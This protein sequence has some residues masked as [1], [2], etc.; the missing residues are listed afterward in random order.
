M[1]TAELMRREMQSLPMKKRRRASEEDEKLT[2]KVHVVEKC[3][4]HGG[5]E[6]EEE[7]DLS[8]P[9]VLH[10]PPATQFGTSK[11]T[12]EGVASDGDVMG[13]QKTGV[14]RS[15]KQLEC[16]MTMASPITA[17]KAKARAKMISQT[18]TMQSGRARPAAAPSGPD[19]DKH[20]DRQTK[21]CSLR[22]LLHRWLSELVTVQDCPSEVSEVFVSLALRIF[23]R[24]LMVKHGASSLAGI[25]GANVQRCELATCLWISM[26]L[27][28]EQSIVPTSREVSDAVGIC[29][30][31]CLRKKEEEIGNALKW[32]FM[33]DH[34]AALSA[35]GGGDQTVDS[36]DSMMVA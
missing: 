23:T 15:R 17:A 35:K 24:F 10:F 22:S 28:E 5:K 19:A 34:L 7:E 27:E 11:G 25:F 32:R 26:K 8:P 12:T 29:D 13:Q 2:V 16:D 30:Y 3:E 9:S 4:G 31:A 1:M 18:R 33:S 6:E 14:K 20:A 21:G 36:I